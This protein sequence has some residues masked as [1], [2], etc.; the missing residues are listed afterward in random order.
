M[1][2]IESSALSE[3]SLSLRPPLR[4]PRA[5]RTQPDDHAQARSQGPPHL[6]GQGDN[7]ISTWKLHRNPAPV[8]PTHDDDNEPKSA[9]PGDQYGL[10]RPPR[11]AWMKSEMSPPAIPRAP[12]RKPRV[13]KKSSAVK[14]TFF[15][16]F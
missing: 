3:I 10:S 14:G 15:A 12:L 7:Q 11:V 2:S 4:R 1:E 8:D 6:R 13:S 5:L 9:A 16:A